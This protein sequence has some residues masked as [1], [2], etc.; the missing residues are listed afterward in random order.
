[1]LRVSFREWERVAFGGANVSGNL[2]SDAGFYGDCESVRGSD[3]LRDSSVNLH[4]DVKNVR[5]SVNDEVGSHSDDENEE[6][7]EE[8]SN[9]TVSDDGDEVHSVRICGDSHGGGDQR[10]SDD[11]ESGDHI[12]DDGNRDRKYEGKCF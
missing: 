7:D 2:R 6:S 3:C 10:V 12:G 5:E 8:G 1:M 4:D 9:M 11:D